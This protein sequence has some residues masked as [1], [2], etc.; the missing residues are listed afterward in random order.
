MAKDALLQ[1][2]IDP[3]AKHDAERLYASMGTNLSEAVRMFINQS[4]LDQQMPFTPTSI[5]RKGAGKAFGALNVFA[6]PAKREQ[7]RDA[8]VASLSMKAENELRR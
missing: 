4:I 2:R 7:E 5:Q 8:W 1:V 3:E 6:S